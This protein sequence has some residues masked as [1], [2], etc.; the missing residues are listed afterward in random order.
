MLDIAFITLFCMT[1][2]VAPIAW[3]RMLTAKTQRAYVFN[4]ALFVVPILAVFALGHFTSAVDLNAS[5]K[6]EAPA[7]SVELQLSWLQILLLSAAGGL[8]IIGGNILMYRHTRRMGRSF[9]SILNPFKPQ[10]RDFT[11]REWASLAFL[12]VTTLLLAVLAMNLAPR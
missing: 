4:I 11:G 5:P 6:T 3:V 12:A 8:W 7:N 10:F 9:W 2:I 1:M